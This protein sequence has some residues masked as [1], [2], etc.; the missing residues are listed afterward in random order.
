MTYEIQYVLIEKYDDLSTKT[1]GTYKSTEEANAAADEILKSGPAHL[2]IRAFSIYRPINQA[3]IG[4]L[5]NGD[6]P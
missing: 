5:R 2:L 1:L 3:I 4:V 6:R